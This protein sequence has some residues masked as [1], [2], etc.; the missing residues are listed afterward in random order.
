MQKVTSESKVKLMIQQ[1]VY[2]TLA[3]SSLPLID[4]PPTFLTPSL[5]IAKKHAKS[6]LPRDPDGNLFG[7]SSNYHVGSHFRRRDGD[8]IRQFG[9]KSSPN[10]QR[11][12]SNTT[13]SKN[14]A[15][16]PAELEDA[17]SG[18]AFTETFG[19]GTSLYLKM[20]KFLGVIFTFLS[21]LQ[22]PAL[23][24]YFTGAEKLTYGGAIIG[25]EKTTLANV[26]QNSSTT[27]MWGLGERDIFLVLGW[28]DV[29]TSITFTVAILFL[30][31]VRNDNYVSHELLDLSLANKVTHSAQE[32]LPGSMFPST[33]QCRIRQ[34]IISPLLPH[35]TYPFTT[36]PPLCTPKKQYIFEKDMDVIETTPGDYTVLIEGLPKDIIWVE[37]VRDFVGTVMRQKLYGTSEQDCHTFTQSLEDNNQK[38]LEIAEVLVHYEC[39]KILQRAKQINRLQARLER[40][41][42]IANKTRDYKPLNDLTKQLRELNDEQARDMNMQHDSVCAFVQ[43]ENDKGIDFLLQNFDPD[44]DLYRGTHK[45]RIKRSPEPDDIIFENLEVGGLGKFC[46]RM[47]S[48][49]VISVVLL[50]AMGI[51]TILRS[52]QK[53]IQPSDS[54]NC[55]SDGDE[56]SDLSFCDKDFLG[57]VLAYATGLLTS[58]VNVF[59]AFVIRVSVQKLERRRLKSEEQASKLL[60]TFMSQFLNIAVIAV[61]INLKGKWNKDG[62]SGLDEDWYIEV[63]S[64]IIIAHLLFAFVPHLIVFGK[65]KLFAFQKRKGRVRKCVTQEELNDLLARKSEFYLSERFSFVLTTS[66]VAMTFGSS[67]PILMVITTVAFYVLYYVDKSNLLHYYNNKT[68]RYDDA[69]IAHLAGKVLLN[70][71]WVRCAFSVWS[72]R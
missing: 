36:F 55:P 68:P 3:M 4:D 11:L 48:F 22:I 63:G 56:K 43:F 15:K 64:P 1:F 40:A 62:I 51:N 23:K 16:T 20:V 8:A 54:A 26:N 44:T 6:L 59:L 27:E 7:H 38:I 72:F 67:M 18:L 2:Y 52:E 28:F 65:K 14:R 42:Y 31:K 13:D 5:V 47:S 24:V 30:I 37:E 69:R 9:Y 12:Y 45:I 10:Q 58:I 66:F 25:F 39:G 35:C 17:R 34:P 33:R 61:L 32:N 60:C 46:G 70:A 71:G 50:I 53:K 49:A 21:I 29:M 41:R 57:L 19:I